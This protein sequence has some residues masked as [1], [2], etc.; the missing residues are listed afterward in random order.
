MMSNL[1]TDLDFHFAS[2]LKQQST[3]KHVAPLGHIILIPNQ[4]AFARTHME[5]GH[6]ALINNDSLT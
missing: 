3:I 6:L 2:S 4:P 5:I 1:M